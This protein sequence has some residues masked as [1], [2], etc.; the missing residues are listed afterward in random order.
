MLRLFLMIEKRCPITRTGVL[1]ILDGFGLNPSQENNAVAQAKMPVYQALWKDFPHTQLEASEG[2]V[3]LPKG[4]MGNSEVGHL[5]IGAGRVVFQDFSLIS[6]AIEDHSF[7]K[8]PV[9]LNL[10]D[11]IKK[12][13]PESSLHL[14]GLL[15][16]GGVHSHISH[17][18]ALIDLAKARGI[19]K[20]KVHCFL[21]GRDTSPSAGV[22][23]V[24][25]LKE[26]INQS[27]AGEICTVMGRFFAMDRDTRWERTE[28]AY[29][30]IVSGLSESRFED[31]ADYVLK[32]YQRK[33][34]DE[35]I[36]PAVAASYGGLCDGDGILFFNFRAD[37]A[38][39]LTRALTQLDFK[40]FERKKTVHLS[41]YVCMTPYDST[42]NLACAF[43][44]TKVPSTLG[45]WV[46]NQNG[47][48]LRIAETEKYAHVTYFFNGGEDKTFPGE[49]R[50]LIPS[51]REVKTY[52]LKPEMSAEAVTDRLLAELETG[53]Y[54]FAVVNFAN[55]DMVGHTGDLKAAI[56]ALE[57]VDRCLGRIVDWIKKSQA[58]GVLT[59][60]HGN[61][62]M[63]K[64]P[65]GNP[66]TSH[67]LLPVP[68][69]FIDPLHPHTKLAASGKLS[70]I[71]PTFLKVWN[72][73]PPCEMTGQSLIASLS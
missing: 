52:D 54:Q 42:L 34:T 65:Q 9:L 2:N 5:N 26:K 13:A 69:I 3:G 57:T 64:D 32:C 7:F 30:A 46:S 24:R 61:C 39:Q 60:D 22:Q 12:S 31:P 21:D 62:E 66:L 44:K 50:I 48:Q 41:G 51:P 27:Q 49:N 4:F 68:F 72:M 35:F 28:I 17:L 47:K 18:F 15:S 71:A 59:A 6:R 38:R 33:E 37:R 45:E 40:G 10:F 53:S 16:D 19:K 36:S 23:F 8:N 20:I 58:F 29:D 63:M 70:D 67:T 11:A 73:S 43:E 55:P 1:I 25:Q 14:M 56:Q